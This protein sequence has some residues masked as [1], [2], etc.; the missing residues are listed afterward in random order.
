[1]I[2]CA[3]LVNWVAFKMGVQESYCSEQQVPLQH[4]CNKKNKNWQANKFSPTECCFGILK[5][6][7]YFTTVLAFSR[8]PEPIDYNV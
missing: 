5:F 4:V 6:N 1:M 3:L 2:K 7:V 8:E